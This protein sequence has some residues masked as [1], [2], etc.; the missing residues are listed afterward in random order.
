ML[1]SSLLLAALGA[2]GSSHLV[3]WW[4]ISLVRTQFALLPAVLKPQQSPALAATLL[5]F[6][7]LFFRSIG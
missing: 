4:L 7:I 5:S 1:G 2:T 6:T 3:T